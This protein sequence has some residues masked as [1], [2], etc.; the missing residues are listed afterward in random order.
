MS[1]SRLNRSMKRQQTKP[2]ASGATK[3]KPRRRKVKVT[4]SDFWW[5]KLM[6]QRERNLATR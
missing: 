1:H 5:D 4:E 2:Y 6:A 3:L